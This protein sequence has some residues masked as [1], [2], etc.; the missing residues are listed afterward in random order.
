MDA[1][2]RSAHFRKAGAAAAEAD[3]Q[4]AIGG[5]DSISSEK[6]R[7]DYLRGVFAQWAATDPEGALNHALANF[8][9]GQLQSDAIGIAIGQWAQEHPR[10]AWLWAE[11]NLTGILKE[12]ALADLMV[13]WTRRNPLDAADWLASTGLTSQPLFSALPGTWAESDPAAAL[14]WARSLPAGKARDTAEVAIAH[15]LAQNDPE[16]AA[17]LFEEALATGENTAVAITLADIWSTTDPAAAASWV[18]SMTDGP[19]KTEAAATLATV[20]AATD[21]RAAVAWSESISDA[22]MRR[23]VI[24]NIGTSWGAIDPYEAFDWLESLPAD[25]AA[26][27]VTG[28]MYSWAGSDPVGLR[29]WIDESGDDPL[30][31]RARRSL[32]DVVSQEAPP[33]AMDLALAMNSAAARDAALARYYSEWRKR[34]DV[35][36]Q[37]WL[38]THWTS[39]PAA[40]QQTLSGIQARELQPK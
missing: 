37:D 26:D 11:K 5:A 34:D 27:G 13:G 35:S 4:G 32:G 21:I 14:A 6:D 28:A 30:V 29:Q 31:D 40:S 19:G 36:A 38:E 25:L 2:E 20:W 7:A 22:D 24:S 16:A 12:R 8:E 18:A 10:E 3:L 33:E 9:A 23:Q 39:L 17:E 15:T 1:V